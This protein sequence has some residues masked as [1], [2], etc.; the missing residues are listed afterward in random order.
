[1]AYGDFEWNVSGQISFNR[2][3]IASLGMSDGGGEIY[4]APGHKRQCNYFEGATIGTSNYMQSTAN[5]FIE[6]FP[7]GLFYGYKTNG[8]VQTGERGYTLEEGVYSGPGSIKYCDLNGNGYIES[9]DRT[10]IGNPNPDFTYGFST[11]FRWRGLTFSASFEGS[12][13]NDLINANLA[14]E[15]SVL[16]RSKGIS[17]TNIRKEY[18]YNA[19]T[20][21]KPNNKYP[22]LNACSADEIRLFTDRFVE[23]ASYLRISNVSLNYEVPL[24]LNKFL[25][26]L[27]VGISGNN[28]YVFTKYSGWDPDVNSYGKN[29][30][31]VGIDMG[32]YPTARTYSFDLRFTF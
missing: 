19:W 4:L 2:N 7:V 13:G 23:D 8:I 5:I 17:Q 22:A 20:P 29:L 28:L 6:G 3:S 10:I 12:Y 18:F 26:G 31:K 14:Q 16:K 11:M 27:S 9:G 1:M 32:S 24:P 15:S 30:Q 21:E 25:K